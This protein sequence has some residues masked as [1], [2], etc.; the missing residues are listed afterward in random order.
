METNID[1]KALYK[2][3]R[4]RAKEYYAKL[5]DSRL[6]K[7][8]EDIFPELRE[9]EDERMLREIKRYIKEQGD[10]PT[11]LPNGTASVS[12][13]LAW[14]EKQKETLHVQETCKENSDSF[15]D[16][17]D[18]RIRKMIVKLLD[19][20]ANGRPHTNPSASMC[21]DAILYLERQKERF[22]KPNNSSGEPYDT[23]FPDAQEYIEKRGF[24]IPWNDGEV[25]VD[26]DYITQTV[27]SILRWADEHPKEQKPT[28]LLPGFYFITE[29]GK[30]YYSKELRFD[31]CRIKFNL[32]ACDDKDAVVANPD[33]QDY[34]GLTEFERAIHRGFLC[35]GVENVPVTIIKETAHDCLA[36]VKPAEWSDEDEKKRQKV[37]RLLED[38]NKN[39]LVMQG[40]LPFGE[41]ISWLKSLRPQ[42]LDA[43]KLENYDPVEVLNR[44]KKEWPAAWEKV[45]WKPSKE[46]MKAL[47]HFVDF[48]SRQYN[49]SGTRW[50]DYEAFQSLQTDLLKL[51]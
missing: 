16:D 47:N 7:E 28:D 14:L 31:D 18:E 13:M 15:T 46:Q 34:S 37:I 30:K 21:Q 6:K 41:L 39:W 38:A 23:P 19:D 1:Y 8:I 29:D 5:G 43:S 17:E 9:S 48:H 51:K 4:E 36:K 40:S 2:G 35:A 25:F 26:K 11:G 12:D 24:A 32:K 20:I 22:L 33:K 3:A 44:I 27:A 45:V 50:P 10:K 49:T 42:K